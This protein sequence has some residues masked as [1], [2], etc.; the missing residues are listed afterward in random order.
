MHLVL[1]FIKRSFVA[2]IRNSSLTSCLFWKPEDVTMIFEKI[3]SDDSIIPNISSR[4]EVIFVNNC[5]SSKH[6][7]AICLVL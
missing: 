6:V 7:G 2:H 5:S 4:R 3:S 1:G